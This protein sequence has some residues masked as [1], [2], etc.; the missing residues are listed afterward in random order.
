M[1]KN[2]VYGWSVVF[3]GAPSMIP[4]I[5][6]LHYALGK[7]SSPAIVDL[8]HAW[9]EQGIYTDALNEISCAVDPVLGEIGPLFEDAVGDLGV[10]MLSR[11][12]AGREL[13]AVTV[14]RMVSGE[15]PLLEGANFLYNDIY[16]ELYE[17]LPDGEYV[18]SSF[19]LQHVFSWLREIWDCRDGSMILAYNDRPREEAEAKFLE[20][21]FEESQNWLRL[22]RPEMA[23]ELAAGEGRGNFTVDS[24]KP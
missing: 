10:S 12:E 2:G 16:L 1:S 6:A 24:V 19:G 17:E 15:A 23:E 3:L 4:R 9:L 7:L 13:V 8:C 14:Y 18:G 5:A 11:V 22:H 21:L 20:H